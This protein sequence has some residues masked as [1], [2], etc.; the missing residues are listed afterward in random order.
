[1]K[2]STWFN[3]YDYRQDGNFEKAIIS[4]QQNV[5][6]KT[7]FSM[8]TFLMLKDSCRSIQKVLAT[9]CLLGGSFHYLFLLAG[10]LHHVVTNEIMIELV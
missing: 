8:N 9:F 6:S 3:C 5:K 7:I 2:R 10:W 1:M 4:G